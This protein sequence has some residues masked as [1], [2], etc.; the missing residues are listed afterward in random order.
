MSYIHFIENIKGEALKLQMAANGGFCGR[1]ANAYN[2]G[3]KKKEVYEYYYC[4]GG[5]SFEHKAGSA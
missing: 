2:I 5:R 4:A 1:I 3:N